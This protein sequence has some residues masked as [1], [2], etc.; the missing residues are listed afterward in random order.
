MNWIK[1]IP[2]WAYLFCGIS[3]VVNVF[4]IYAR[5]RMP[6]DGAGSAGIDGRCVITAIQPDSPAQKAGMQPGDV[7]RMIGSDSVPGANH[8]VILEDYKAGDSVLYTVQRN[9]KDL[10]LRVGLASYWSQYPA[11]YF[12][13]YSLF[14]FIWAGSIF[15]LYKKPRDPSA[16]VFFIYLQLYSIAQNTRFLFID[17][18]YAS[19]ANLAFILSFTLLGPALMHFHLLFPRKATGFKRLKVFLLTAYGLGGLFGILNI[20]ATVWRNYLTSPDTIWMYVITRHVSVT[21]MGISLLAAFATAVYQMISIRETHYRRQLKLVIIGSVFGLLTPVFFSF[22]PGYFWQ[23]E[24]ERHLLYLIE[25]TNTTGSMI[26]ITCL[27]TAIFRYRIWDIEAV[28]RKTILY[29]FT[30]AVIMLIYFLV[31]FLVNLTIFSM[32]RWVHFLVIASLFLTFMIFR[33]TMKNLVDRLFFRKMY[34][35]AIVAAGFEEKF[36]VIFQPDQLG[37]AVILFLEDILHFESCLIALRKA[38]RTYQVFHFKGRHVI[39]DRME[40]SIPDKMDMHLKEGNVFS[41]DS[42]AETPVILDEC[43]SE[44]V[45]PMLRGAHPFGFFAIGRKRSESSY[46]LQDVTLLSLIAKRVVALLYTAMLYKKDLER[47]VMMERERNR[48]SQDMHDEIGATLTQISIL[49]EVVR[50]KSGDPEE[51]GR[52][53]DQISSISGSLVDE[54]R[55]IIWAINPRNDNL[56]S[57]LSFL[58][59]QISIYLENTGLKVHFEFPEH[60]SDIP[61]VSD[62]RRNLFLVVKEA[63]HNATKHSGGNL[64]TISFTMNETFLVLQ[65]ED[66]GIGFDIKKSMNKGNGLTNMRKRIESLGGALLVDSEQGTGTRITISTPFIRNQN[67]TNS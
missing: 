20:V 11:V 67:S 59:Q 5:F 23:I 2:W 48:I 41:V 65:I 12:I 30:M 16:R 58:R 31:L 8:L 52:L 53:L 17:E 25:L 40:F 62:Q 4:Y 45:I 39:P 44:L 27:A 26:M 1:R 38:G 24:Q 37:A 42:M 34:D 36:S 54:M 33:D 55:D 56:P 7:I 64:V 15:I 43:N 18:V 29:I 13:L 61:M 66:N 35:S 21:W 14:L 46:T 60:I 63:T 10:R 32:N 6:I 22:I 3:L 49:S 50:R 57:F 19:I 51:T 47:H 28:I 9:G